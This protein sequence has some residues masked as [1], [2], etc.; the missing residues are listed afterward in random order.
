MKKKGKQYLLLVVVLAI[1]G[2]VGFRF[3][4]FLAPEEENQPLMENKMSS[5]TLQSSKKNY[6]VKCDYADPFL[7]DVSIRK[8]RKEI[9]NTTSNNLHKENI[10]KT[11]DAKTDQFPSVQLAGVIANSQNGKKSAIMI[12]DGKEYSLVAGETVNGMKLSKIFSDSV[13]VTYQKKN[14]IIK[15]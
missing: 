11:V 8:V 4:S 9:Y 2:I 13:L 15:L 14:K 10:K 5:L 12:L 6:P 1:W 3:Y 7:K